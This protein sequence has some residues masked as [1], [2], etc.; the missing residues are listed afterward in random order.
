MPPARP[1]RTAEPNFN[2]VVECLPQCCSAERPALY[3]PIC[4]GAYLL[5]RYGDTHAEYGGKPR[6]DEAAADAKT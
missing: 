6:L 2:C 3:A 5:S 1:H 4:A